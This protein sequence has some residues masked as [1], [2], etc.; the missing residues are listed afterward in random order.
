MY[1]QIWQETWLTDEKWQEFEVSRQWVRV[2][3]EIA[4]NKYDYHD[5][6]RI[7]IGPYSYTRI[8]PNPEEHE[9]EA[10]P[11]WLRWGNGRKHGAR[12]TYSPCHPWT[13]KKE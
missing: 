13:N 12:C 2:P 10:I 7:F 6:E 5:E 1:V 11:M 4:N 3:D 8:V 9:G